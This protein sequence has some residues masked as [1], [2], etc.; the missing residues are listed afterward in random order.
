MICD[1]FWWINNI[2]TTFKPISHG[3]PE[4]II[5]SDAS[6]KGWGGGGACDDQSTGGNWSDKESGFHINYLEL[7][8]AWF[9]LKSFA[10]EKSDIT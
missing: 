10:K 6:L 1:L 4:L 2:H 3:N 7:L 9:A 8:A 5:Y